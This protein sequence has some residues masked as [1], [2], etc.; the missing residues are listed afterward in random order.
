M[1]ARITGVS[2][3]QKRWADG[4]RRTYHYHRATGTPL[5]GKPGSPEFT[6]D[7]AAAEKLMLD[8]LA[9][10][11]DGLV[12]DYMLSPEF[13]TNLRASTQREYKRMLTKIE[14]K[15]GRVPIAAL[16][17]PR[18][19]QHFMTRRLHGPPVNGRRTTG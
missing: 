8:R 6:L 2:T 9:G 14:A 12:R 4:S 15:F 11:L 3:S 18:V 1:R 10:T 13:E 16:E 5:R 7:Y 17:D 19:R